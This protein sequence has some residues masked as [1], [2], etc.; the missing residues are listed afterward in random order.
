MK[1]SIGKVGMYHFDLS[2]TITAGLFLEIVINIRNLDFGVYSCSN[3]S[4]C[5]GSRV[6]PSSEVSFHRY[7]QWHKRDSCYICVD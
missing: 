3:G 2:S 4:H 1:H 6:E 5:H 7:Y